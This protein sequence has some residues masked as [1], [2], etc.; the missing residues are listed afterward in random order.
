MNIVILCG[1]AGTHFNS[2]FPK[3]LN[4]VQ[5]LPMIYHVI[6]KLNNIKN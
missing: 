5:G 3:P 4:L 1:G 2:T 6:K